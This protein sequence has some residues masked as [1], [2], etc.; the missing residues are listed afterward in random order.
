MSLPQ[1]DPTWINQEILELRKEVLELTKLMRESNNRLAKHI[2]FIENV[3]TSLRYPL[4]FFKKKLE[5]LMG[6]DSS[7][8]PETP[9]NPMIEDTLSPMVS[10]SV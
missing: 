7:G 8:L 5:L 10:T 1:I 9:P 2:G 4:D 6:R 3:Y